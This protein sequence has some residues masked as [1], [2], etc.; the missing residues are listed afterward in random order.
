MAGTLAVARENCRYDLMWFVRLTLIAKDAK[1]AKTKHQTKQ[2]KQKT[3]Q[4][5]TEQ[6]TK[7]T[8]KTGDFD[9]D[10]S[11][12]ANIG[13]RFYTWATLGTFAGAAFLVTGLWQTL[14]SFQIAGY[15]FAGLGWPLVLSASVIVLFAFASEPKSQTTTRADKAQKVLITVANT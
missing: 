6:N 1:M 8:K 3:T 15:D 5:T 13:K 10:P 9:E 4:H 14:K 12:A 7:Q 11:P 2:T